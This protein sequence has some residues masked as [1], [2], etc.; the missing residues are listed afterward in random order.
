MDPRL[1]PDSASSPIFTLPDEVLVNI[2]GRL[3]VVDALRASLVSYKFKC[4]SLDQSSWQKRFQQ[5]FGPMSI[6]TQA[7]NQFI[8]AYLLDKGINTRLDIAQLYFNLLRQFVQIHAEQSW[9]HYYLGAINLGL[10][11]PSNIELA[12]NH[13][14]QGI[15][16]GDHRAACAAAKYIT[17]HNGDP[18]TQIAEVP[19]I[20][21]TGRLQQ[22][23]QLLNWAQQRGVVEARY[24]L[25][26]LLS[27]PRWVMVDNARA[28]QL[29]LNSLS[30]EQGIGLIPLT[31]LCTT[32][33]EE[34]ITFYQSLWQQS[35]P[36]LSGR[37]F[38]LLSNAYLQLDD[39]GN[40]NANLRLAISCNFPAALEE[41]GE[42][43]AQAALEADEI[44]PNNYTALNLFQNGMSVKDRC[45]TQKYFSLFIQLKF[46]QFNRSHDSLILD[47]AKEVLLQG[48]YHML[49][50]IA[51]Y[52]MEQYAPKEINV[53]ASLT[54]WFQLAVQCGSD[55]ALALMEEL[56]EY[57]D[58]TNKPVNFC[59]AL[60]ILYTLGTP[61]L[62]ADE[63]RA[64]LYFEAALKLNP[65]SLQRYIKAG[66]DAGLL[67]EKILKNLEHAPIIGE[68]IKQLMASRKR[69]ALP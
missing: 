2:F 16:A 7:R 63:K 49:P 40:A 37:F 68:H 43:Y 48:N 27:Q 14:V 29:L 54:W 17:Q 32:T 9:A 31:S 42:L 19:V 13:L 38:Y 6:P 66:I 25:G 52:L 61:D 18:E 36:Q 28:K 67:H 51:N 39:N 1:L 22:I 35:R 47:R 45:C 24:Y 64:K 10:G 62:V 59:C 11:Q 57:R 33:T 30:F 56:Y 69:K 55:S 3:S 4:I 53:D 5:T 65:T 60:G 41:L 58:E 34:T 12:L 46:N 21:S 26:L 23:A 20:F 44:H 50:T 8:A 15:D